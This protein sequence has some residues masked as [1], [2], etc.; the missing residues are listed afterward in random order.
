[1]QQHLK[2]GYHLY[3]AGEDP[4]DQN[5][6]HLPQGTKPGSNRIELLSPGLPGSPK[7]T[8]KKQLVTSFLL[9][10]DTRC[11]TAHGVEEFTRSS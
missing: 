7:A 5:L 8:P 2:V 1:M 11:S 10:Q 3:F 9:S 6:N 4:E